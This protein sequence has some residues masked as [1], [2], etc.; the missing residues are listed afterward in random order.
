VKVVGIGAGIDTRGVD[1]RGVE[2]QASHGLDTGS[3]QS[4]ADEGHGVEM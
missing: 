2:V 3:I 4:V 1:T